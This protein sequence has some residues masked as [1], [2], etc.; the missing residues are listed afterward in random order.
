MILLPPSYGG[1]KIER[2]KCSV[3]IF[4]FRWHR[5]VNSY[6]RVGRLDKKRHG[7]D[8]YLQYND[9]NNDNDVLTI[10]PVQIYIIMM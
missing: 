8:E 10:I 4:R 9:I 3:E 5:F 1:K 2:K 7:R 6:A